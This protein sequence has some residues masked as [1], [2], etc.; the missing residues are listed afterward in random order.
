MIVA[1]GG[2]VVKSDVQESIELVNLANTPAERSS[3]PVVSVSSRRAS[4][5]TA[6][7]RYKAA[8]LAVSL[9][10]SLLFISP[11]DGAHQIIS[12][13]AKNDYCIRNAAGI[14]SCQHNT[15]AH[16]TIRDTNSVEM[17]F[18]DDENL[19][20]A[21]LSV[22]VK[23]TAI[24]QKGYAK[25]SRLI[26]VKVYSSKRCPSTGSC[27]DDVCAKT[28]SN[29]TINELTLVNNFPGV[30]RCSTSCGCWGCGCF[31]CYDS[32]TFFRYYAQPLDETIYEEFS[33]R[34]W[35]MGADIQ[36][37]FLSQ[38]I[39]K[40]EN[41]FL[42]EGMVHELKHFKL[43]LP[44]VRTS[45]VISF[46][47]FI[48][49]GKRIAFADETSSKA[50]KIL[51]CN[52]RYSATQ[53]Q[54]KLSEDTCSCLSAGDGV[55]C[56]CSQNHI[57]KAQL[58]GSFFPSAKAHIQVRDNSVLYVLERSTTDIIVEVQQLDVVNVV[59]YN[60][61]HFLHSTVQGCANCESG[62]FISMTCKS[63]FSKAFGIIEC[64][65]ALKF[66]ILCNVL[67]LL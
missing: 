55:N 57:L 13:Q 21:S 15:I 18:Q 39:N 31:L 67:F 14:K 17:L 37:I 5:Q 59:D 60:N 27:V 66:S 10:L 7:F 53:F 26:D 11:V 30:T 24:C 22:T 41:F 40:T 65:N 2:Y 45:D 3:S 48:F 16:F 61:C 42:E 1:L 8:T 51:S 38:N 12:F 23:P 64:D 43:S 44:S 58:D 62:A 19:A 36:T 46:K 4:P 25:F 52:S 33:C 50:M 28:S 56:Q 34:K 47:N 20:Q 29:T 9:A 35:V 54:C 32:C 49:D 63:D 6:I